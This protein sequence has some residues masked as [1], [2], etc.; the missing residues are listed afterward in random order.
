MTRQ[1]QR[2]VMRVTRDL[3][4][5]RIGGYGLWLKWGSSPDLFT[6]RKHAHYVGR[7]RWKPLR[8]A[9]SKEQVMGDK[10]VRC[11]FAVRRPRGASR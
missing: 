7:F 1:G 5:F 6:T 9:E 3:A 2:L 11:R 8:P 4:W 10:A